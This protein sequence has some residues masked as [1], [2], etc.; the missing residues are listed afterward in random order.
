[1][2]LF[3]GV[4]ADPHLG[5]PAR[6]NRRGSNRK[7]SNPTPAMVSGESTCPK[8]EFDGSVCRSSHEK[9]NPTSPTE[10]C[11]SQT[12]IRRDLARSQQD[13]SR[14]G[15]FSPLVLL[16]WFRP[17]LTLSSQLETEPNCVFLRLAMG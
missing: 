9:L 13:P 11:H 1:M 7:P 17:K 2:A 8:T 3:R 10:I 5:Q 14:S 12:Q 6:P 16:H 15:Q 4:Q